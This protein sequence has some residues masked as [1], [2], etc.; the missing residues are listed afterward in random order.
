MNY[1]YII[2][3]LLSFLMLE[4]LKINS[5]DEGYYGGMVGFD[6]PNNDLAYY[7]NTYPINCMR[8]CDSRSDCYGIVTS[9][10]NRVDPSRPEDHHC[11]LK[12]VFANKTPTPNNDRIAYIKT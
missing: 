4:L 12:S 7:A 9:D 1:I 2:L 8:L 10:P 6:Y 3:L 5:K 11:W